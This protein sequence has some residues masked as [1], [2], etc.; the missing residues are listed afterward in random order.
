MLPMLWLLLMPQKMMARKEEAFWHRL[1]LEMGEE[2]EL[3]V[4]TPD[5]WVE[6]MVQWV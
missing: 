4:P 5:V 6:D 2:L 1:D 3:G